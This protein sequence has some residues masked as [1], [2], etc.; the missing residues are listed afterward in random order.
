MSENEITKGFVLEHAAYWSDKEAIGYAMDEAFV[1]EL[2]VEDLRELVFDLA[3]R[4][5]SAN[6]ADDEFEEACDDD[7]EY[8]T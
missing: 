5:D 2:D 7:D 3:V 1:H 4:L 6:L 8:A